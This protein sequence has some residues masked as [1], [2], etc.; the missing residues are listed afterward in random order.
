[1]TEKWGRQTYV[2]IYVTTRWNNNEIID[3][4][5]SFFLFLFL[6]AGLGSLSLRIRHTSKHN[7]NRKKFSSFFHLTKHYTVII[8]EAQAY[9]KLHIAHG[10]FLFNRTTQHISSLHRCRA[11]IFSF[12]FYLFSQLMSRYFLRSPP[13]LHQYRRYFTLF[14]FYRQLFC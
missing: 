2:N 8:I 10:V 4:T 12:L 13:F 11:K 5:I 7:I 6:R 3:Q 1:M 9:M 14:P